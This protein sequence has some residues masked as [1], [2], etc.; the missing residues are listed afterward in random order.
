[1][2]IRRLTL[3]IL[4]ISL[5]GFQNLAQE[6]KADETTKVNRLIALCK[7]WGKVKY[8]HPSLAYRTDIDWDKAL[9]ETVPKV[10]AAKF[11]N[12]YRAALQNMLDVLGDPLTRIAQ[13]NSAETSSGRR[14]GYKLTDDK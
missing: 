6:K 11:S 13:E 5:L 2:I 12:E 1:M 3:L 10:N 14:L 8:F 9:V 4:A 7:L